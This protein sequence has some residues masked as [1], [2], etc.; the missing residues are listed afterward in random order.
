[1]AK[2]RQVNSRLTSASFRPNA[3]AFPTSLAG[4]GPRPFVVYV[5]DIDFVGMMSE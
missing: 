5:S 2:R 4:Q 3:V 1:M